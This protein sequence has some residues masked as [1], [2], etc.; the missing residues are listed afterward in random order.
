[1]KWTIRQRML[2]LCA[3]AIV[4][5]AA[6]GVTAMLTAR[7]TLAAS[8]R[9][10]HTVLSVRNHL[11]ADMMRDALRA[12]VLAALAG[13]GSRAQVAQDLATHTARFRRFMDQNRSSLHGAEVRQAMDD[14]RPAL[15]R[16]TAEGGAIVGLASRGEA[17]AARARL[18]QF[19]TS[20]YELETSM[21]RISEMLV[22]EAE[23]ARRESERA[24]TAVAAVC[25]LLPALAIAVMLLAGMVAT[26]RVVEP[27]H[28]AVRTLHRVAGGDLTARMPVRGRDE[29]AEMAE[30]V[31]RA[32]SGMST[33][34]SGISQNAIALG[35]ASEELATVAHQLTANSRETSTQTVVAS[36]ASEQVNANVRLV[37]ASAQEVG[38]S[39]REVANSAQEAAGVAQAAVRAAGRADSTVQQLG[40]SSAEIGNVVK[41]ITA[42]ASQTNIL[43]LNAEI[44]AARAGDAGK[45]FAVVANEVKE[46]AK[47]TA[48][49]T[50]DIGRRVETIQNDSQAA[51]RAIAEIV[52][53][54]ER[55]SATQTTIA[56]AV[57]EQSAATAGITRNMGEAARGTGEIAETIAAVARAADSTSGGARETQSAAHELA[58]M[59]AELQRLVGQFKF[60]DD[61]L[62]AGRRTAGGAARERTDM[63]RAA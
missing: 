61:D 6:V 10:T 40:A 27:I 30:A 37:A 24:G 32:T 51:V 29:L 20:F 41:V 21:G 52:D 16:Y 5:L 25:T 47:E 59:A 43:A 28:H 3:L 1:V 42:I 58:L 60:A 63:A 31:N 14:M 39:I 46:L 17:G 44:E 54:I 23:Q 48:R 18:P 33:A 8:E 11:E 2:A 26:R 45:G 13:A 9:I 38:A 57:E 50:E 19:M 49:A 7:R 15:E 35:N 22:A 62:D 34:L 12:D 55:I 36:T 4:L 56:T 53:I